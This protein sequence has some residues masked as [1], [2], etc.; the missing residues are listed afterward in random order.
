MQVVLEEL[1]VL[2]VEVSQECGFSRQATRG[3]LVVTGR[4]WP[5]KASK[6]T[7]GHT[8]SNK[9]LAPLIRS[10]L[11]VVPFP[12]AKHSNHQLFTGKIQVLVGLRHSTGRPELSGNYKQD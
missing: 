1:R 9:S 3:V 11:L 5:W 6:S 7:F 4:I 12:T 2:K 8:L 10:H